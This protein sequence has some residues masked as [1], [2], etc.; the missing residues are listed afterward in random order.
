MG[1][2][3]CD[4][5][6][7]KVVMRRFMLGSAVVA[8][9]AHA[10]PESPAEAEVVTADVARFWDAVDAGATAEDFD[11]RYL[12]P[13]SDGL[14]GLRKAR[15]K[16]A[17]ALA[18]AFAAYEGWY[19]AGRERSLALVDDAS[20]VAAIEAAYDE[21]EALWPPA[22][23]PPLTFAF[24]DMNTG[25]TFTRVRLVIGVELY[26]DADDAPTDA[27]TDPVE[28][29]LGGPT[30]AVRKEC[31]SGPVGRSGPSRP[32]AIRVRSSAG[33]GPFALVAAADS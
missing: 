9:C 15:W 33:L 10:W 26:L 11:T 2:A 7:G 4:R 14:D 8:G 20:L 1:E 19:R 12:E 18:A 24:G 17:E 27:L 6:W 29:G 3:E 5:S 16:N 28:D 21:A 25:G 13:A 30:A 32:R 22:V 31:R 23:F